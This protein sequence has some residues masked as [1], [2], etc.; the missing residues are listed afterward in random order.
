MCSDEP[1]LRT[2]TEN[3]TALL[4][5]PSCEALL[6]LGPGSGGSRLLVPQPVG[7]LTLA[8]SSFLLS[9]WPLSPWLE[10]AFHSPPPPPGSLQPQFKYSGEQL[11]GAERY[12]TC[13]RQTSLVLSPPSFTGTRAPPPLPAPQP[14][15]PL[16]TWCTPRAPRSASW[17]L[18]SSGKFY[19]SN[20]YIDICHPT[21]NGAWDL[22]PTISSALSTVWAMAGT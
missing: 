5:G 22:L 14:L 18:C 2:G 7:P 20:E 15:L 12:F 19:M 9:L 8:L 10:G 3:L 21:L 11:P 17:T 16:F 4:H 1:P 6:Q 13:D